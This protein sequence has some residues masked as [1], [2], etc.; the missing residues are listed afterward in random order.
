MFNLRDKYPGLSAAKPAWKTSRLLKLQAPVRFGR[1]GEMSELSSF[2]T[3]GRINSAL[4]IQSLKRDIRCSRIASVEPDV[5]GM[6]LRKS[7]VF[8]AI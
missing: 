3:H 6:R 1:K 4:E 7:C 5:G 2:Q 8:E